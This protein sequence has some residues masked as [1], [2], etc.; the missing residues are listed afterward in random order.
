[1]LDVCW[2][3][4]FAGA[5]DVFRGS[6]AVPSAAKSRHP[7]H[8]WKLAHCQVRRCWEEKHHQNRLDKQALPTIHTRRYCRGHSR[9]QRTHLFPQTV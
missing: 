5:L 6:E 9:L 7:D 4:L 8:Q 2:V 1:M 3:G